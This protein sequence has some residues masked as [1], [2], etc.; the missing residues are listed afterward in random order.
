MKTGTGS[1]AVQ[2]ILLSASLPAYAQQTETRPLTDFTSVAVGG[3]IDLFLRQ[4]DRFVVEVSSEDL[5]DI[6]TEVHTGTLEISRP[7]RSSFFD[8][9]DHGS[10]RVTLPSLAALTASGGSDVATEGSISGDKLRLV[11]SGGSDVVID[12]S[13]ATLDVQASGGSDVRLSG[14]ARS[15]RVQ[16]SGGS[17]LN[18]SGLTADEADVNSSGGSDLS[19][20]VRDKIV[21]NASG[22]SDVSYTGEPSTV[23]VNSSGGSDVSRR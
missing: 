7:K 6:V 13:V 20:A 23:D 21:G 22:G 4:G 16:S 18:A 2:L 17:D 19:I 11:A 15:A 9:G 12:V 8:W 10:V 1:V 3:G 14:S 5:A